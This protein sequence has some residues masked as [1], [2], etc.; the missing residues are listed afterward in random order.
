MN[1]LLWAGLAAN[2]L[3]HL[4]IA[5]LQVQDGEDRVAAG[6]YT[7]H[8]VVCWRKGG[9]GKSFVLARTLFSPF[10]TAFWVGKRILFPRGIK[11]QFAKEQEAEVA[12]EAKVK[13][14]QEEEQRRLLR[15]QEQA[16]LIKAW[17]PGEILLAKPQP[18]PEQ[19]VALDWHAAADV[20]DAHAANVARTAGQ[21]WSPQPVA[22]RIRAKVGAAVR[23]T[24]RDYNNEWDE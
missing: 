11:S 6:E 9:H 20:F 5:V 3:L 7:S 16:A 2:A 21:P 12:F 13:A 18:E 4:R 22:K 24:A 19:Q 23:A 14:E 17:V 8:E 10:I 1:M 15:Y